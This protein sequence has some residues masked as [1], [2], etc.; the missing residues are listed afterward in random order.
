MGG[1]EARAAQRGDFLAEDRAPLGA[2]LTCCH[3]IASFRGRLTR[4][5]I[6][7]D[8]ATN[9]SHA[10]CVSAART[11]NREGRAWCPAQCTGAASGSVSV[12]AATAAEARPGER[13]QREEAVCPECNSNDAWVSCLA[14]WPWRR[15]ALARWRGG[16]TRP[17]PDRTSSFRPSWW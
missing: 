14:S 4:A 2:Q 7:C 16:R 3:R 11:F 6:P 12:P 8:L 1:G 15:P 17:R 13:R 10:C 9:H 5:I